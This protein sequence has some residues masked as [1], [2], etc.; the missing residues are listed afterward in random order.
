[1][2]HFKLAIQICYAEFRHSRLE[3]YFTYRRTG[4]PNSTTGPGTDNRGRIASRFQYL[5]SEKTAS[6]KSYQDA[7]QSQ[8]SDNDNIN[9]KLW[10]LQ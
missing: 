7:L 6:T 2:F 1:M 4:V 5:N 8:Y 10:G 3:S 9:G